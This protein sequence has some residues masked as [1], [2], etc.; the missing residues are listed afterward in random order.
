MGTTILNKGKYMAFQVTATSKYVRVMDT[1]LKR[2]H[3]LDPQVFSTLDLTTPKGA[4]ARLS[5]A[6]EFTISPYWDSFIKIKKGSL[7]EILLG[8]LN[9]RTL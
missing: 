7:D 9:G 6:A 2:I 4:Q 1:A 3:Y 8:Y 5:L